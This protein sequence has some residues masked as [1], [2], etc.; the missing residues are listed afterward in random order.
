MQII[1][2]ADLVSSDCDFT[3]EDL[4]GAQL[5]QQLG[6]RAFVAFLFMQNTNEVDVRA[7]Y[8]VYCLI[9]V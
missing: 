8:S 5:M 6:L 3:A 7:S 1:F 9:Y 4:T 2:A